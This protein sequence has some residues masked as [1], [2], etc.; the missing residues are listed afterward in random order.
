M[1][2][3]SIRYN[4]TR[5]NSKHGTADF[6]QFNN[7][8]SNSNNHVLQGLPAPSQVLHRHRAALP[9]MT[10]TMTTTGYSTLPKLYN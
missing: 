4:Q 7:S 1:Q 9:T 5:D 6:N 8:S 10:A 2:S 3:P